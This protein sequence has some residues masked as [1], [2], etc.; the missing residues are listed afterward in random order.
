MVTSALSNTDTLGGRFH[1]H[2]AFDTINPDIPKNPG[3]TLSARHNGFHAERRSKTFMVGVDENK[4]SEE[5]LE[6]LLTSMVDDH[7]TVVCVR[8]IEKDVKHSQNAAYKQS[9]KQLMQSIIKKNKLDKAICIILEYQFGR[10]GHTFDTMVNV[11][12]PSMLV[13]GTKGKSNQGMQGMWNTRHSF[14][15]YCLERSPIPVVVV[16]PE[17]VRQKKKDKRSRDPNRASYGQILA[18]TNGIH[19]SDIMDDTVMLATATQLSSADEA[20]QVAKALALPAEF[21]PTIKGIALKPYSS[22]RPSIVLTEGSGDSITSN[23]D[24][25]A[26]KTGGNESGADSGGEDDDDDDDDEDTHDLRPGGP[27]Q[28]PDPVKKEKLHKMEVGEA[29]ALKKRN[30]GEL[31]D[32]DGS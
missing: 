26:E 13:V 7:D 29:A 31:E 10:L 21:D 16:R 20:S 12:L 28:V 2:V 4:Y 14:S 9:A 27:P 11:H 1:S 22:S 30:T 5:A 24:A 15:K 25:H 6:W 8:V 19:E 23:M 32:E 3:I 17:E 18:A